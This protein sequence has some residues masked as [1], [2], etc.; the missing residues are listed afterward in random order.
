VI[1]PDLTESR[2]RVP[3]LGGSVLTDEIVVPDVGRYAIVRD[4]V[5]ALIAPFE[6]A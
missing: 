4:N 1:V 3:D 6:E 5:G 2:R